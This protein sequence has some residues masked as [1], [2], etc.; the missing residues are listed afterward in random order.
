MNK[1]LPSKRFVRFIGG[2]LAVTLIVWVCSMVFGKNQIFKN[3]D[4]EAN[5]KALSNDNIHDAY[6]IDSD[7][8]GLYDWEEGLWGTDP[9][10]PKSN[11]TGVN[12][13]DYVEVKKKDIQDKNN[14]SADSDI[15]ANPNQTEILARQF[16][17][18]ASLVQQQGGLSSD[19]LNSFSNAFGQT[20]NNASIKDPFTVS[21]VKVGAVDV[22]VYKDNLGKDFKPIL[23]ADLEELENIYELANGDDSAIAN[24]DKLVVLYRDLSNDV[25]NTQAPY[26]AA[27]IQLQIINNA[28]KLSIAFINLKHLNDD[29]LLAVVGF[30]E[31]EQYSEGLQ[32]AL[33]S[34]QNYFSR[35]GII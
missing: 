29:P 35:N 32:E 8:D 28:S 5:V 30:R 22:N 26:D 23:S 18:T 11:G 13:K 7:S 4:A 34:L 25:L 31:Y 6:K 10:D 2:I 19:S 33:I 27:G 12:D 1:Y 21:D 16:L 14:L 24:I 20:L 9:N 17:S 15:D 3:N